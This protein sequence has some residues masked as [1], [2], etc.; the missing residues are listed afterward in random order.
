MAGLKIAYLEKTENKPDV[1][2]G[3]SILIKKDEIEGYTGA[4]ISGAAHAVNRVFVALEAPFYATS[5]SSDDAE[6]IVR[7]AKRGK[8]MGKSKNVTIPDILRVYRISEKYEVDRYA[9]EGSKKITEGVKAYHQPTI[10]MVAR[11]NVWIE[12]NASNPAIYTLLVKCGIDVAADA[13]VS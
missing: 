7:V 2:K 9:A 1:I 8:D 3:G 4:E 13:P 10:G 6:K 12:E 5:Y 11:E